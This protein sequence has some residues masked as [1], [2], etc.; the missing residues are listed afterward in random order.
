VGAD[1][2][3]SDATDGD[4]DDLLS[5]LA[6]APN[7]R[8]AGDRVTERVTL[9]R[10]LDRGGMGDVWVARH[11][12]L[13]VDV[14]V[15]FIRCATKEAMRRFA[16]EAQLAAKLTCPHAVRIFDHGLTGDG[17]PFIVMELLKGESLADRIE[18]DGPLGAEDVCVL[19]TQ[20]AAAIDEA[21][22]L[23]V[24]HR[25]IKP[26][27]LF[28][29]EVDAREGAGPF[30][31]LLDF[32]LARLVSERSDTTVTASGVVPGTARYQAPEQ[33]IDGHEATPRTD[34]WS[35]GV[36][37]YEALTGRAPFDGPT[38]ASIAQ[39]MRAPLAL[40]AIPRQLHRWFRRALALAPEDRFQSAPEMALALTETAVP[41][42]R[43]GWLYLPVVAVILVVAVVVL[44]IGRRDSEGRA[45]FSH[46]ERVTPV[47]GAAT[48]G[49]RPAPSSTALAG[50][51]SSARPR[52]T[53]RALSA[54]P[55]PAADAPSPAASAAPPAPATPPAPPVPAPGPVAEPGLIE[56]VPF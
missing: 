4:L 39:A 14:A 42:P 30:V 18:R 20:L 7:V 43:R 47:L 23:D 41:A 54:P 31:R 3:R 25:D 10:R 19:V 15:K 11:D 27:N 44:P 12:T 35:L 33:L 13:G 53:W 24:V 40:D 28:L 22:Q 32:G 1:E 8:K 46:A 16:R 34:L 51:A 29:T 21:H 56:D 5:A 17:S 6:A 37:A 2:S 48:L 9:V 52:A 50:E 49:A 26:S 45:A 36:V 38:P 55:S